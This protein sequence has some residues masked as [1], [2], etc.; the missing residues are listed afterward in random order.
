MHKSAVCVCVCVCVCVLYTCLNI[1]IGVF[2]CVGVCMYA[3]V[4]S[5]PYT[6][7]SKSKSLRVDLLSVFLLILRV[8]YY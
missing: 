7:D 1:S 8:T 2:L 5:V 6:I 3:C 4:C